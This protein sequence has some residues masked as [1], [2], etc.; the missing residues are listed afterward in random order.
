MTSQGLTPPPSRRLIYRSALMAVAMQWAVRLI[1]LVSVVALARLLQPKDFGLLAVGLT[2]MGLVE[3]FGWIGLRQALLRISE[4]ER[5][6]YDT[7]FTIQFFLFLTLAGLM[8]VVV[9]PAA[10]SFY[11]LPELRPVLSV[12]AIQFVCMALVNIAVVDFERNFEFQRDLKMRVGGRL[13]A[14]AVTLVAA[15]LLR[16]YWALVIGLIAQS[17]FYTLASYMAH[18]FRPRLSLSKRSDLMST[19][20]WLFASATADWL[21]AQIERLV[22]GRFSTPHTIGLYSTSKDLALMFTQEISIALNRV[23]FVTI[24]GAGP[25]TPETRSRVSA[26]M[27]A[28]AVIAAPLAAGL[29]ASAEDAVAVLLSSKWL[30]ASEFLQIIAIYTGVQ[31]VS[32]VVGSVLQA[33]GRARYAA[34][35]SIIGALVTAAAVVAAALAW[36][37][38]EAMAYSAL[39]A[40]LVMFLTY[41]IV[42]ARAAGVRP[43][44]VLAHVLRPAVAA[45]LMF[46]AVSRIFD[47]DSGSAVLDLIASVSA[48]VVIYPVALLLIWHVFGRPDG[49]EREMVDIIRRVARRDA[50]IYG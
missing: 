8:L 50:P 16:D 29:A 7:A 15:L 39:A 22:L 5:A 6:H 12:L 17:A 21:Q 28:Y 26:I 2:A 10:A 45:L 43:L 40:S 18:P 38:P 1:G 31:A 49:P 46:L 34:L 14:L 48:G 32:Y 3:L 42:L 41:A 13:A 19:S 4:P 30:A 20:L 44:A 37:E 33:S 47:P 35:L 27:G 9:A 36:A 11:D 23:T 24:A 25:A